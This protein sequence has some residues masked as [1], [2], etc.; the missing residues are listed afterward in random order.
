MVCPQLPQDGALMDTIRI[1]LEGT[2]IV[3][4]FRREVG[5][6][7]KVRYL[8]N[9]EA[10]GL[11]LL[12]MADA[13]KVALNFNVTPELS[14]QIINAPYEEAFFSIRDPR[15]GHTL[16]VC[17]EGETIRQIGQRLMHL[18]QAAIGSADKDIGAFVRPVSHCY[19]DHAG[20]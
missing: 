5:S 11:G 19:I 20:A 14:L 7:G 2:R 16:V 12:L 4:T 13:A 1:E 9:K 3:L 10:I 17:I 6:W 18:G 8:S 15:G